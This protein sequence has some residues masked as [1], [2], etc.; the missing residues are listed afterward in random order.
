MLETTSSRPVATSSSASVKPAS[1]RILEVIAS[2]LRRFERA[3]GRSSGQEVRDAGLYAHGDVDPLDAA[4]ET[5]RRVGVA[6]R[7]GQRDAGDRP[8]ALVEPG[9]RRGGAAA[10]QAAVLRE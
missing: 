8:D 10:E 4:V 9:R 5:G 2:E 1:E 7:G 3:H 6:G